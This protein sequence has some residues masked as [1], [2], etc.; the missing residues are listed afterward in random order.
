[1]PDPL[2]D[3]QPAADDPWLTIPE[4]G[5]ELK[6]HPATL[7]RWVKDGRLQAVRAGRTWRVRRSDLDRALRHAGPL[8]SGPD[9]ATAQGPRRQAPTQIADHLIATASGE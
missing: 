8:G 4:A 7:R 1:M 5:A 9:Q 6:L 2:F 3:Q